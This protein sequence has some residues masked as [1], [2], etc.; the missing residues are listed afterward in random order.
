MKNEQ[1][2]PAVSVLI[3]V[4]N[5]A[6]TLERCLHSVI[7]QTM[8]NI[9]IIC[10]DDGS[11]EKTK[12][13]LARLAATDGR[14]RVFTHE[15]NKG[16]MAARK[17]LI[18]AARGEYIMFLDSD[19]EYY[20]PACEKAYETI[21][22]KKADIVQFGTDIVFQSQ[23]TDIEKQE[24]RG[25]AA[26][27]LGALHGQD[28]FKGCFLYGHTLYGW[29][30]WNKIYRASI[31]KKIAPYLPECGTM[32]EDFAI[33][34]MA[35]YYAKRYYGFEEALVRYSFGHGVSGTQKWRTAE[36]YRKSLDRKTA[37]DAVD[38]FLKVQ[39]PSSTVYRREFEKWQKWM[40]NS[41]LERFAEECLLSEG[42]AAFTLL[43]EAY[44]PEN[45][46]TFLAQRYG[47][48]K[49]G[50]IA[51][52]VRNAAC[53]KQKV[54]KVKKI[55]FFYH[56]LYNGGVERV[57]SELIPLFD[58]WG[59]K[60]VLFVEE[61][62]KDDYPLPKSCEVF[63]IESS[64]AIP[65]DRYIFH[66]DSF[67][68]ALKKSECDTLLYQSTLSPWFLYDMLL[69]QAAGIRV[70]GTLHE[71]VSLPLLRS[72]EKAAFASRQN[73]LKLADGIQAMVKSDVEYLR[74]LGCNAQYIPN[75]TVMPA[76]ETN[77]EKNALIWVGRF[78]SYQKRPEHAIHIMERVVQKIP[79]ARL[80]FVGT[81]D[82]ECENSRFRALV[83]EKSLED[84]IVMSGFCPEP[85]KYYKKAS[86]LL[87]T[88]SF[89]VWGMVLTESMAHGLPIVCYEMPYLEP[90][91]NNGGCITVAQED[92]DGAADAVV[93]ILQDGALRKKMSEA[94]LAKAEE[95]YNADLRGAWEKMFDSF[96]QSRTE[97]ETEKDL[98][99]SMETMLDFYQKGIKNEP[100]GAESTFLP[101]Q[102]LFKKAALFW[103]DKGTFALIR[104]GM[105]Y[106]Y[107]KIRRRR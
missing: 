107:K 38:A 72:N 77:T 49:S 47:A 34:F 60:T 81:A 25:V 80:Y 22:N 91:K 101:G 84:N 13:E 85:Q 14:I 18:E 39:A 21:T 43:C 23:L 106:F 79:D 35:A 54:R 105:L 58:K 28:V 96:G 92:I 50:R 29:N 90:L 4:Y 100:G 36:H 45:V 57:L 17:H 63:K 70:I 51:E 99:V 48:G 52:L 64:K 32:Y 83:R 62:S 30:L 82:S 98:R 66:A 41:V 5:A 88:S 73:I 61:K 12:A 75:P 24:V 65:N 93:R 3:P 19:D 20:P 1:K 102:S 97:S 37:C 104:K 71:L 76:G 69:A 55:G 2:A 78:E 8:R 40:R 31:L 46:I 59:Y 26:A 15:T 7:A 27:H 16:A 53:L 86:L 67:L 89:E 103:V 11:D 44:S 56:R 10:V 6:P 33:Y 95:L 94:A 42:P 68:S 74:V 87:M 9:E